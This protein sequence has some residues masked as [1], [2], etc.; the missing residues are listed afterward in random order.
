MA[1]RMK[2]MFV[3]QP[4]KSQHFHFLDRTKVYMDKGDTYN[5]G[6]TVRVYFLDGPMISMD[7]HRIALSPGWPD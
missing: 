7:M 5:G 4:S 3:N 2:R 1:D 6:K